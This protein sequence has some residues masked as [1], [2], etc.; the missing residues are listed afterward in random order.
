MRLI[1]LFLVCFS[2][3]AHSQL[4]EIET[5][6][7]VV[8]ILEDGLLI[9]QVKD[10]DLCEQ[11]LLVLD[12][13]ACAIAESIDLPINR[14]S[15]LPANTPYS[16]KKWIER[17]ATLHALVPGHSIPESDREVRI[18]QRIR[19]T[20]RPNQWPLPPER[21]GLNPSVIENMAR[22]PDLPGIVAFDTFVGNA[23]RSQPNLFYDPLT[24]RYFGIDLAAAFCSELG[25]VAC[26]QIAR[27]Q[28]QNRQF[29]PEEQAALGLYVD[30]LDR[31]LDKWSPEAIE[32][33]LLKNAE[34]A[35]FERAD[36]LWNPS[37]EERIN[38]HCALIHSNHRFIV[39]LVERLCRPCQELLP[40]ETLLEHWQRQ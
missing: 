18:H 37:V 31:L 40:C 22:H 26:E 24:D 11:F 16:G 3:L 8:S 38:A 28:G 4:V 9:K 20:G 1:V 29:S 36:S 7:C 17:P 2:S 23:D 14:V 34:K 5:G 19:Q 39:E 32:G 30:T 27:Y 35:G 33:L 25:R 15:L 10:P 13:T 21:E 12:A 6:D